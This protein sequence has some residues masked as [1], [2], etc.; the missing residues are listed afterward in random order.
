MKVCGVDISGS[1]ARLV[2][3]EGGADGVIVC[4]LET[5]RISLKDDEINEQVRSFY[6]VILALVRENKIDRIAIKKRMK[7]GG[8]ASGPVSFKIE[9]LF[10]MV[11]EADVV[12]IAPTTISAFEKKNGQDT[13]V[14]L[15]KYQLDAYR[16]ARVALLKG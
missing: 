4:E 12:L 9:G 15:N 3:V 10:Q 2:V 1:E 5:K 11:D 7:A 14:G 13:P 16:T 6:Q 8:F